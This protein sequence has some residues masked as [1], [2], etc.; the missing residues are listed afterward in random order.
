LFTGLIAV[1]MMTSVLAVTAVASSA[2]A[3]ATPP[4]SPAVTIFSVRTGAC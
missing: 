2:A 3:S 1:A 4:A